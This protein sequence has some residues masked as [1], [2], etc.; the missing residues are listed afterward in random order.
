MPREYPL[1]RTRNIGIMAHI[2]A[3]KTTTTERIL[4]YTGVNYK[5]GEVHD[6]AATMDYMEQEQERGITIT[7]AA[8]TCSWQPTEGPF[9]KHRY[10]INIIDTP[11]PR[12]LHD[13][14]R[15]LAAR[16]R[17]C[18]RGVR[19]RR[20]R[21]AAVR[22]RVASGRP[23]PR[24][25]HL[26]H[27]QDGPRRRQLPRARSTRSASA[28]GANPVP[29]QIPLG[30]E[31]QHKGIVD[32]IKM[33]AARL[34]G[35]TSSARSTTR[36]TSPPSLKDEA[37]AAREKL[38]EAVAEN[39][40]ALMERYL[41]GDTNFSADE[42]VRTLRKG[43]LHF[44]L[45]RRV[46][47]RGVQEQGRAAAARRGRQLPAV[48]AR[49]PAGQGHQP[50]RTTKKKSVRASDDAPFARARVQDH[51]RPVRRSADVHARLLGPARERHRGAQLHQGQARA[52]R[53]LAADAREQA[54]GDQ[55]DPGGQHLR[56]GR[57]QDRAHRRHALR[58]EAP[59]RARAHGVP[60]AGHLG[61]DRAE[62]QGRAAKARRGAAEARR[63]R[64]RRSARTP[65]KRR[66]RPSSAAW[67]SCT[68]RSSS[69]A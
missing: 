47:R 31:D 16:A 14:G 39:D 35:R 51:Q 4:F 19:R 42:I 28:S 17:R 56:G 45:V 23:L 46:L 53:S 36:P 11:G 1:E 3:G 32:L 59:D 48:A 58:R 55:G 7:S 13:R 26:L 62:D 52:H 60:G 38:V 66:V 67:A 5:I 33:K 54:R 40:D 30:L 69:T 24:A 37:K 68:S 63:P 27:Q 18:G 2:D 43:T 65:T 34:R 29:I 57:P 25:A 50:G 21:R 41:E 64:T 61:R 10:R 9:A 8:T 20:R 15:A 22:D 6:G 49:H 12:R 44:K